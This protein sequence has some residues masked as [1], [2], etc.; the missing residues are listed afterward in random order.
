[1]NIV[2]ICGTLEPGRDGVG[3]YTLQ[4]AEEL[5]KLGHTASILA[6]HDI[7]VDDKFD[8]DEDRC[9]PNIKILRL[10]SKWSY[11]HRYSIAKC[12]IKKQNPTWLS[13]QFVVFAFQR[14]GLPF[15]LKYLLYNLGKGYHWQIMFHELWVGMSA[16]TPKKYAL[17]GWLQQKIILALIE[18]LKPATVHTQ[19][20][21]YHAH[22]KKL[23]YD[24]NHLPLFSNIPVIKTDEKKTLSRSNSS[25]PICLILFGTI[26]PQAQITALIEQVVTFS[27]EAKRVFK[28]ILVG[29]CG[30]HQDAWIS[31][32]N[33]TGITVEVFGEQ[34][35]EMIS[36]LLSEADIG[37]S[38]SALPIIDKSGTVAAMFAH[39]LPVLC[40]GK[41]WKPKNVS[42]PA[43]MDGIYTVRNGCIKACL[44]REK[45]LNHLTLP[46]TTAMKLVE[47]L[48]HFRL[49]I[50]E[51][52]KTFSNAR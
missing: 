8:N 33:E 52:S 23:G 31:A 43:A 13:L 39:D 48:A 2:L 11:Y 24:V 28:L 5:S 16:D 7:Y 22:L 34:A 35:P 37:I 36:E 12:W 44:M 17:W 51:K 10:P 47:D 26:H 20:M 1:M 15:A 29:K 45:R 32:F 50:S 4:L 38:T 49:G 46:S 27:Q 42:A 3:D 14:K 6:L 21:L 9:G 30:C 18:K 25:D 19:S 41:N 40:V